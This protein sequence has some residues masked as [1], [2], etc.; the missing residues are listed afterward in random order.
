MS[1]KQK[2]SKIWKNTKHYA[3]ENK[4]FIISSS[5]LTLSTL[6]D[7]YFTDL[8]I[9]EC[10]LSHEGNILF[11]NAIKQFGVGLGLYMPKIGLAGLTMGVSYLQNNKNRIKE[12]LNIKPL[13]KNINFEFNFSGNVINYAAS[14]YFSIGA[15]LNILSH[16][17]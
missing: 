12:K 13:S 5:V 8:N 4:H 1:L 9:R 14:G 7:A 2:I 10:G 15:G 17:L 11:Y 6:A 16:Y 3:K